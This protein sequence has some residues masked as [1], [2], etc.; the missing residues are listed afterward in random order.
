MLLELQAAFSFGPLV[1]HSLIVGAKEEI[2]GSDT[3]WTLIII[4][5]YGLFVLAIRIRVVYKFNRTC[6]AA[7]LQRRLRGLIL[8]MDKERSALLRR[9][10]SLAE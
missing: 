2:A 8:A 7:V 3:T 9:D 5:V 4:Y 1:A 10:V 6:D